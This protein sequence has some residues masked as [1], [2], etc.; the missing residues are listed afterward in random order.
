MLDNDTWNA[1]MQ[2]AA[3]AVPLLFCSVVARTQLFKQSFPVL[4]DMHE[5]QQDMV[6]RI[7]GGESVRCTA[8][9]YR[10]VFWFPS[11]CVH[12][13]KASTLRSDRHVV[14]QSP[15]LVSSFLA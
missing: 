1:A 9:H 14:F 2:G 11:C 12:Q 15:C 8:E 5:R 4:E 7:V 13:Q 6:E 3:F 10:L